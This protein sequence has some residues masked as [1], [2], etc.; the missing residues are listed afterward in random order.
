[1][2]NSFL[3]GEHILPKDSSSK[4]RL[5]DYYRFERRIPV[6]STPQGLAEV[7][8]IP[9]F[10]FK[11]RSKSLYQTLKSGS[12]IPTQTGVLMILFLDDFLILASS[13]QEAQ[14]N[15]TMAVTLLEFLGFIVNREK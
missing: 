14:R 2:E 11:C 9:L 12:S 15:T 10:W 3:D 7:P 1:M 4:R 13:H 8:T 6:G 5:H